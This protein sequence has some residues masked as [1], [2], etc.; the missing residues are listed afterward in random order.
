MARRP[1]TGSLAHKYVHTQAD[2]RYLP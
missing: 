2:R 1:R